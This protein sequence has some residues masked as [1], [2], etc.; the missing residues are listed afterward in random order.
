[1]LSHAE[2]IYVSAHSYTMSVCGRESKKEERENKCNESERSNQN[3]VTQEGECVCLYNVDDV[4]IFTGM[5]RQFRPSQHC[6]HRQGALVS[7]GRISSTV[8]AS[9]GSHRHFPPHSFF[10]FPGLTPSPSNI[11]ECTSV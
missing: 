1:M 5:S 4:S 9:R 11:G 3:G 8:G 7:A 2:D 6:V 10:C